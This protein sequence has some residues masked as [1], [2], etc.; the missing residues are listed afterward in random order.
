MFPV[1]L[2][3]YDKISIHAPRE[4]GDPDAVNITPDTELISIHA[5]REGGDSSWKIDIQ[6][7]RD[8]N[9]RPPR[10][11]R[12]QEHLQQIAEYEISIHAPREGGDPAIV[13]QISPT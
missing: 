5:P 8:F 10:G 4:G 13:V 11:G 3:N 9:P 7:Q 6:K 1:C 2:I 12:R